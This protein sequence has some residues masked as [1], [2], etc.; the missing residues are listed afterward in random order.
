[1]KYLNYL[2]LLCLLAALA[3]CAPAPAP[4]PTAA[5][6]T[7]APPVAPTTAPQQQ[8]TLRLS[9]WHLAE[10]QWEKAIKDRMVL[11]QKDN[12][13]IKVNVEVISYADKEA[14]YT[15][16]I[17]AGTGPDLIHL[18]TYGLTAFIQNGYV[19]DI[20][21]FIEKEPKTS[22]GGN[23]MDQW[24]PETVAL[25][26]YKGKYYGLPS[27]YMSMVM[28]YNKD[29]FK[30]AGLDPAN[31][32]K[33]WDEFLADSKKLTRD[34]K[35]SGKTDT[36]GFGMVGV[37]DPGW[38]L[39]FT[40]ILTS[41]GAKYLTPDFKCSTLNSPEAKEAVRFWVGLV[42]PNQ[43]VPPGVTSQSVGNVR[44]QM[45]NAQIAMKIGSG[46]TMP[47][48]KTLKPV[49]DPEQALEAF[50]IPVKAGKTIEKPTTA[51]VSAWMINK[52]TK[53]PEQAWQLLKFMTSQASDQRWFDDARVLSA[54]R[55][56]SGDATLNLKT[57]QP[58]LDDKWSKV[59][60]GELKNSQFV[61]QLKEWPQ[62]ID[63]VN[64]AIQAQRN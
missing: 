60:A 43:V 63:I 49:F 25:M 15:T 48:Q 20:T 64:K 22:W 16:E 6:A 12:P 23:F 14:K 24:Y 31:P 30:E 41:Y 34:R 36:W 26:Q 28:F 29:L 17:Q 39:R 45:A 51:W 7:A 35:S 42:T 62:I 5:P 2:L 46:W 18:H 27:D 44:T 53:Y 9:D 19:L 21:P 13:N 3:A 56:V 8:V 47:I 52:N 54:R 61:P 58:I 32:P 1:M 50:P 4:A 55:D 40:P 33:T 37:V 11:F 57:Y 10:A 38:E 59:I